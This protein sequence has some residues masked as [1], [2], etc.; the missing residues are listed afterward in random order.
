MAQRMRHQSY[1]HTETFAPAPGVALGRL[2]I[3]MFNRATQ[4]A[5]TANVQVWLCGEFYHQ[6]ARRAELVRQGALDA[7]ADDVELALQVYLREGAAGLTKLDGAFVI[8]VWDEQRGELILVNDRFGLYPHYYAHYAGTL[9]IAPEIKGVLCNPTISPKANL[10]AIAEYTRFQQL[11]GDKTWFED[12]QL[13]P[14]ASLLRYRP[15]DD[16]FRLTRYWDWDAIGDLS[17]ISF[18]D[19]VDESIRLFQRAIDAMIAG[20]YRIG[21]YLSGGLDGRTILGFIDRQVPVTTIN[22]G[23]AR[24]RDV[25]YARELARRAKSMHH[26]FPME[27]GQWVLEHLD[28]HFALTEGMHSWM[29]MHGIN[30]LADARRWMDV[31]L[32]GWD[33]GTILGGLAV[34]GD[35]ARDMFFKSPQ[36]E[37]TLTQKMFDAFCSEVTWPGLTESE[38]N[39]LFNHHG[40]VDL[41]GLAFDSFREQFART[42]HYPPERRCAF[43]FIEQHNRR[44]TQNM[45][46]FTRAALEVRCPF[47]DYALITFLYALPTPMRASPKFQHEIITRRMP[48]LA[49]VPNEKDNRLPH[50]NAWI[51]VP[52]ALAQRTKRWIHRRWRSVFPDHP[53]LYADYEQ[54][55]RTDLR[56]W[57]EG[58]LF[59]ERTQARGLFDPTAVRALWDRHQ[60]GK[61]LWTIGKL[62]PLMTVEMVLREFCD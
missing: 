31:N 57:A 13:L 47:F 30:T 27:N 39:A 46:V 48:Q 42:Q 18:D 34:V 61:E 6:T 24:S 3:G 45:V 22:F 10:T 19:A 54:Y 50:T 51:R 44:S 62:A 15:A 33:G 38:A 32:S 59:N 23:Q 49:L 26:W 20:P 25:I 12:I 2:H 37:V 21:V 28:L 52:H 55:L 35:Y 36:N 53:R 4:P 8:A 40:N 5:K 58:L 43:F 60:S 14:P 1:H 29:H 56:A 9:S 17:N 7:N 41:C 16:A 11:L